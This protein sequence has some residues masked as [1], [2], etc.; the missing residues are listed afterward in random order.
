MYA[1]LAQKR[2]VGIM[3][4][5]AVWWY[6][7]PPWRCK[8][9]PVAGTI[10][11]AVCRE[12]FPGCAVPADQT[13]GETSAAYRDAE[14]RSD[15]TAAESAHCGSGM[16]CSRPA[17][18]RPPRKTRERETGLPEDRPDGRTRA[19]VRKA[20]GSGEL[21]MHDKRTEIGFGLRSELGLV[22]RRQNRICGV[23]W[24]CLTNVPNRELL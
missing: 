21:Q 12:P 1:A 7:H 14:S 13:A 10:P 4:M 16:G 15:P 5:R 18:C 24:A 8:A 3:A 6:R 17:R 22:F 2:R 19:T 20:G 11:P 9:L 23:L